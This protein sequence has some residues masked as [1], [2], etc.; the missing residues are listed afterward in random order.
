MSLPVHRT[1]SSFC[2][3]RFISVSLRVVDNGIIHVK[4][5]VLVL[6]CAGG[7]RGRRYDGA[8][9][10]TPGNSEQCSSPAFVIGISDGGFNLEIFI[11]RF[12]D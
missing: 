5:P 12:S 3:L 7:R 6:S 9:G 11:G 8:G 2:D 1:S 10:I 4:Q